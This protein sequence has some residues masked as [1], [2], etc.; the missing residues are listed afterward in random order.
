MKTKID[1]T[2]LSDVF[3]AT[4]AGDGT[5]LSDW[6]ATDGTILSDHLG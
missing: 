6:S 2:I 4:S 1:G 3:T 5:I